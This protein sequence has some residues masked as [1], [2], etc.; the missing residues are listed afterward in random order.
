MLDKTTGLDPLVNILYY[1]DL[2]NMKILMILENY[3][4]NCRPYFV[5]YIKTKASTVRNLMK[6]FQVFPQNKF[7]N[8]SMNS[9][10]ELGKRMISSQHKP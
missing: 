2:V 10:I 4:F 3:E 1:Q 6:T 7:R 8:F 5:F 9:F